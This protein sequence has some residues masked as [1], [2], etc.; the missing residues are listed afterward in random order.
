MKT[1]PSHE[2]W[3]HEPAPDHEAVPDPVDALVV[4]EGRPAHAR[5][6]A[7]AADGGGQLGLR[8][9][10]DERALEDAVVVT[11]PAARRALAEGLRDV[12]VVARE[13]GRADRVRDPVAVA[14][15]RLVA[16]DLLVEARERRLRALLVG[17]VAERLLPAR[18]V[19]A[20]VERRVVGLEV[21]RDRV[22]VERPRAGRLLGRRAVVRNGEQDAADRKREH[23][24]NE[25]EQYP[26][27]G[28]HLDQR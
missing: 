8:A 5:V 14:L 7:E 17:E 18:G 28:R 19:A 24:G 2:V 25:D 26:Q 13:R 12:A 4:D 3:S 20:L 11:R 10:A 9:R 23:D 6:V 27:A 16:R 1:P 21:A 15:D 22:R